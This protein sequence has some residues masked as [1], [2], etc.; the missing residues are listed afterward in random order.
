MGKN[1]EK[2]PQTVE[3]LKLAQT[4]VVYRFVIVLVIMISLVAG[5]VLGYFGAIN[6]ITDSQHKAI[7]VVSS[8]K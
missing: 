2:V 6:V 4:H 7:E 8:L 3:G 5:A 1:K